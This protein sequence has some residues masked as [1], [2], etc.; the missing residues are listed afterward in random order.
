M[1]S[2]QSILFILFYFIYLISKNMSYI[3]TA[4]YAETRRKIYEKF[5]RMP[6]PIDRFYRYQ[7]VKLKIRSTKPKVVY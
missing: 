7:I 4:A 5:G 2:V 6:M 1:F 3:L